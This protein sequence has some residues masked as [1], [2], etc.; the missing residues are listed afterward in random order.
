MKECYKCF[1]RSRVTLSCDYYLTTGT[2]VVKSEEH[3][4]GFREREGESLA[5]HILEMEALY[6]K[7]LSD[8]A[9]A[10]KLSVS[11]YSVYTW[12]ISQGLPPKGNEQRGRPKRTEMKD[13]N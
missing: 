10:R 6:Y 8:R 5:P 9:I 2:R 13:G 3:C 11:R 7:G 12:R 4:S 1:Y